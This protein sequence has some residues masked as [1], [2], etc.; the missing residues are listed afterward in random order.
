MRAIWATAARVG[1]REVE[2]QK[3]RAGPAQARPNRL[4]SDRLRLGSES[5]STYIETGSG[6]QNNGCPSCE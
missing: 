5:E 4:C 6:A 1:Q 2:A 3:E